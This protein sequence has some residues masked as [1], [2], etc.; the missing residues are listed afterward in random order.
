[1]LFGVPRHLTE[2][3][4]ESNV[5]DLSLYVSNPRSHSQTRWNYKKLRQKLDS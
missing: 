1:M 3:A 4:S 5:G 2:R